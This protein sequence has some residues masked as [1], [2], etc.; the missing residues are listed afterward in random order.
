MNDNT[1]Q[2]FSFRRTDG[3]LVG[4]DKHPHHTLWSANELQASSLPTYHRALGFWSLDMLPPN[5]CRG[6]GRLWFQN[7]F[8]L[9]HSI[10]QGIIKQTTFKNLDCPCKLRPIWTA[11]EPP[12]KVDSA[13]KCEICKKEQARQ[14]QLNLFIH[15]VVDTF[16]YMGEQESTISK[17]NWMPKALTFED[18]SMFSSDWSLEVKTSTYSIGKPQLNIESFSTGILPNS[19]DNDYDQ[20]LFLDGILIELLTNIEK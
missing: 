13:Q 19:V 14:V 17:G 12:Q 18:K 9:F 4:L 6:E 8:K 16:F 3:W 10:G 2:M 7:A 5:E 15:S 20:K 1:L 11:R